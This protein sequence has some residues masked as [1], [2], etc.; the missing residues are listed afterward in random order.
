MSD[1]P[2]VVVVGAGV[3]GSSIAF[4]LAQDDYLVTM[5]DRGGIGAGTSSTCDKAI[6]LQSKRPGPHLGLALASRACFDTLQ[7]ELDATLE[8]DR[9]GGM[10]AIDDAQHLT[11]MQQHVERQRREGVDVT[12]LDRDSARAHQPVLSPD[13]LGAAY[14]PGDAEVNPL[15]LNQAFGRAAIRAG[16]RTL[17]HTPVVEITSSHGHVTGVLTSRGRIRADVVI[18]ATGPFA[19][20]LS[21]TVGVPL[22]ITPSRGVIRI[23]EP[24]PPAVRGVVL[25]THYVLAKQSTAT[26]ASNAPAHGIGLALGQT[27]AGNPLIGSSR[28]F[29]GFQTDV[30]HNVISGIAAHATHVAPDLR[31]VRVIRSMVG[32]RPSTPDGMPVISAVPGLEGYI[33]AA[34]HEGDGIALSPLTGLMVR[35]LLN[36]GGQTHHLLADVSLLRFPDPATSQAHQR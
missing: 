35:D 31:S 11:H 17:L 10:I 32:F 29:V 14:S 19:A 21:A 6:I 13:I 7:D 23:G 33:V 20:E 18:N 12:L 1:R 9:S 26:E 16:A 36:G 25:C 3:I 2:E 34:G 22:P 8:F 4:R 5:L 28:E 30:P 15:L 27:A 24:M